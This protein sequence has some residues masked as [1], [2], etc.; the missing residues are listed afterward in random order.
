MAYP[1]DAD[2][3]SESFRERPNR[4]YLGWL[5]TVP[6]AQQFASAVSI[7]AGSRNSGP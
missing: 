7:L 1:F 3:I 4:A 5:A 6:R 2:A